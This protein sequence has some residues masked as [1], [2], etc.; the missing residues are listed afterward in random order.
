MG[1][2]TTTISQGVALA[3][4]VLAVACVDAHAA[5]PTLLSVDS[6]N[7]HSTGTF[8]AP[9]ADDATVYFATKPDR[10]TDGRFL[11][12]NVADVELLASDEIASGYWL[13]S[14]QL[15]PGQYFVLLRASDYD[16]VLDPGCLDGFSAVLP[17]TV[18]K[19]AQSYRPKV[20]R[21]LGTLEL[22]L[23]ISPL[24]ESQPYRVCWR[25]KSRARKCLHSTV[26]GYDWNGSASDEISVSRRAQRAM[27]RRTKFIWYVDRVG[28][29]VKRVRIRRG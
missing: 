24:G 27:R 26:D 21:L 17:L 29:A 15:D 18:P 9:G 23:T 14:S 28:V 22:K 3:I 2:I 6:Q 11:S 13:S 1:R 10:G 5:T 19:P 20:T 4:A 12:E 16:C 8:S 25:T 7:R